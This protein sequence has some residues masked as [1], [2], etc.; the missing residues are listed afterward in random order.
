MAA[1]LLP[2]SSS[3]S[4]VSNGGQESSLKD[5]IIITLICPVLFMQIEMAI[6]RVSWNT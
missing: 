1:T 3:Q 6:P 4:A 5:Y 2:S